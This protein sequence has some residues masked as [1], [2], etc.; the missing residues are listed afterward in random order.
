MKE[1]AKVIVILELMFSGRLMA[2]ISERR[3]T[4][5]MRTN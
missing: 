5:I 1:M 4:D 3:E 2:G